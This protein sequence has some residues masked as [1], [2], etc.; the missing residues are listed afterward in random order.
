M[1]KVLLIGSVSLFLLLSGCS[2][3][4]QPQPEQVDEVQEVVVTD[5]DNFVDMDAYAKQI[6]SELQTVYFDF[7]KYN[8]K[9]SMVGAVDTDAGVLKAANLADYTTK[10]EGNCDEWGSDEYNYALGLKRA[11]SVKN[12]LDSRG[13]N[14]ND[15][16]LI[17]YGKSNPVCTEHTKSCWAENRRVNFDVIPNK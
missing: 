11:K 6:K 12:G 2:Q 4:K 3:K 8:I 9:S 10:L 1:K 15:M 5:N 17:S 16:V 13:V 14:T 7:D